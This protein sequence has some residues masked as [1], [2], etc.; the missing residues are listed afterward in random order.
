MSR[1]ETIAVVESFF[2]CIVSKELDRLPIAP[3]FTC[4]SPLTPKLSG[5]AALDYARAVAAGV[6][7]IRVL[8]HIVEGDHVATFLEEETVNGPLEVFSKFRLEAGRIEDAR[9][10]YDPRRIVGARE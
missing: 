5:R 1:D 7:S 3:G 4:Q 8:Q 9:V 2:A 10:F 6:K